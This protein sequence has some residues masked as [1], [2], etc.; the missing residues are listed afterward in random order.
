VSYVLHRLAERDLQS[1]FQFYREKG[2]DKVALR[3]LSEFERVAEIFVKNPDIGTP[4][5]GDRRSYPIRSYPY[6]VIYQS[7]EAG[8]RI[9]VVRHQRRDPEAGLDRR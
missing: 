9:L 2:S 8:I 6:S 1:A 3:F 4:T 5:G 7:S